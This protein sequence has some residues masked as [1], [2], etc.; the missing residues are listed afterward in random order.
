MLTIPSIYPS[1]EIDL[2]QKLYSVLNTHLNQCPN[3]LDTVSLLRDAILEIEIEISMQDS[4]PPILV[5][6]TSKEI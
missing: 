5:A 6:M 3:D 1:P 2:I 4:V